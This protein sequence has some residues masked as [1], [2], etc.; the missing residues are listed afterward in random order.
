M[1]RL[2]LAWAPVLLCLLALLLLWKKL[3]S[4]SPNVLLLVDLDTRL[5]LSAWCSRNVRGTLL[6]RRFEPASGDIGL[7]RRD[8]LLVLSSPYTHTH[9]YRH[10]ARNRSWFSNI[11]CGQF[12]KQNSKQ[13]IFFKVLTL[14]VIKILLRCRVRTLS[15]RF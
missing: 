2:L 10:R 5:L 14:N 12:Y 13:Y 4:F 3:C 8:S 9:T 15:I 11:F 7:A 1:W 6:H